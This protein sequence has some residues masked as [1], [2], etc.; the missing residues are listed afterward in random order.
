MLLLVPWLGPAP[1]RWVADP[2]REENRRDTPPYPPY[3][4][5]PPRAP[6]H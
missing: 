4:P 6:Y 3:Q 2:T 5:L 1:G